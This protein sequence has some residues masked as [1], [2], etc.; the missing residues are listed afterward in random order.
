MYPT[1]LTDQAMEDRKVA[2]NCTNGEKAYMQ[3]VHWRG[4]ELMQ[5]GWGSGRW[6]LSTAFPH[7]SPTPGAFCLRLIIILGSTNGHMQI[8]AH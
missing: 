6:G 7:I 1:W 2:E 8:Y 3:V 4:R 5:R